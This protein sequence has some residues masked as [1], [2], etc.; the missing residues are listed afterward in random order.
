MKLDE[1][2]AA[3]QLIAERLRPVLSAIGAEPDDD[4]A[5]AL[6][7]VE[8]ATVADLVPDVAAVVRER[9][10]A[11]EAHDSLAQLLFCAARRHEESAAEINEAL[12]EAAERIERERGDDGR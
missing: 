1:F 10:A 7:T 5:A 12:R 3:A 6:S 9:D 11:R 2:H 4:L 8:A